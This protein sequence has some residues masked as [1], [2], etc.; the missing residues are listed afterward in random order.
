VTINQPLG[1]ADGFFVVIAMDLDAIGN[2]ALVV[3]NK[4]VV[5]PRHFADLSRRQSK[6]LKALVQ[7][8]RSFG[9]LRFAYHFVFRGTRREVG[10]NLARLI[11][12]CF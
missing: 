2:V 12:K 8:D 3:D 5:P 9:L 11:G 10:R 1:A 4:G 7:I 6:R